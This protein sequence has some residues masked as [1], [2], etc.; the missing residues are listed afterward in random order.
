M[1]AFLPVGSRFPAAVVRVCTNAS[2]TPYELVSSDCL[3]RA[4]DFRTAGAVL[5]SYLWQQVEEATDR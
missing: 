4:V 5:A 2:G 1:H 3:G